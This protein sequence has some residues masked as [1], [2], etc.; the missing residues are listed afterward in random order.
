MELTLI[1]KDIDIKISKIVNDASSIKRQPI[2]QIKSPYQNNIDDKWCPRTNIEESESLPDLV[3]EHKYNGKRKKSFK[4]S[5]KLG[6]GLYQC[7]KC[8][9]QFRSNTKN[10][11]STLKRHYHKTHNDTVFNCNKCNFSTKDNYEARNHCHNKCKKCKK[12][13]E[14]KYRFESHLKENHQHLCDKCDDAF[15][16]IYELKLHMKIIHEG[17]EKK[18]KCEICNKKVLDL[19]AH[20]KLQHDILPAPKGLMSKNARKQI[21]NNAVKKINQTQKKPSYVQQ[22]IIVKYY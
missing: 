7:Y 15:V 18:Y 6:G 10:T 3:H 14:S 22:K 1:S 9:K 2:A 4:I 12:D 11:P 5:I 13:F 19:K 17:E 8:D 20:L 21:T 16:F